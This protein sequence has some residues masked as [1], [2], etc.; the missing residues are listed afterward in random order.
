[1]LIS[2]HGSGSATRLRD[3]ATLSR[4][5]S[6]SPS[7]IYHA[8]GRQAVTMGVSFIPGVNV[9]DVGRALESKLDQMSAEKPAGIK[10][11]LFY[12]QAAEVAHSVNG[13]ITNFLMALAIV[14][15][16]LLIFM[17]VRS[18]IIIALSLA[19]NVLGTLLIMYLWGIE[20]QRISLGALII[21][22]SMLVDNAIVIVEGVLIARQQGSTLLTAINYVIRRSALPLLGATVIAI[23]AFAP[24]GLSQD[25]T[26]EYCKSLLQVLLIS[27]MLSWFSALTITPV[28]IKWWLFKGQQP[29]AETS[30]TDPYSGRFYRIYQQIL[31]TLLMRKAITLTVMAALLAASIWGFGSVRQ[32]FFPHRTRLSSLLTSGF[33]MALILRQ[34][35]RWPAILKPRLTA[36]RALSPPSPPLV[37]A[38]CVLSSPTAGNGNTATTRR[39]WYAWTTSAVLTL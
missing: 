16:V 26:G 35:K 32:N 20:L 33:P 23:L 15:G 18:G 25:S 6:E 5:L 22:L 4:G 10:I 29:P 11:D 12:D 21:A 8:N 24:I 39:S 3:I 37:R 30:D 9:I 13:F 19:L 7:S 31:H 38:V 1:L 27:L 36:S 14:V 17:G 34:P 2:P 28:L